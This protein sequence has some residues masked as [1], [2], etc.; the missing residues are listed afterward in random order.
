MPGGTTTEVTDD[1]ITIT[2]TPSGSGTYEVVASPIEDS[3]VT[4]SVLNL[5]L[6]ILLPTQSNHVGII[7]TLAVTVIAA[8]CDCNL[9]TWDNPAAAATLTVGVADT[10][11]N[12]V[13][14]P[15]AAYNVASTIA[16]PEIRVCASTTP[17]TLTY[18]SDLIYVSE[19]QLPSFMS[20]SGT[21]LTVLPTIAAHLGTWTL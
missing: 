12:T 16:T 10:T 18:T 9:V 21:T 5:N 6:Q 17:C 14:I 19:A 3:L 11:S 2:E 7:E 4:G 20:V 13:T 8:T 1:W 15:E